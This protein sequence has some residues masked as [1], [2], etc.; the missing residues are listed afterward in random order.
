MRNLSKIFFKSYNEEIEAQQKIVQLF[1]CFFLILHGL[2]LEKVRER[3]SCEDSPF[4]QH[5]HAVI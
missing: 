2:F 3:E 4:S 1:T 5:F